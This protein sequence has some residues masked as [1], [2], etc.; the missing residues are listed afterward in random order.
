MCMPNQAV[1]VC[2]SEVSSAVCVFADNQGSAT[3]CQILDEVPPPVLSR[4]S[5]WFVVSEAAVFGLCVSKS[6]IALLCI[7]EVT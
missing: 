1:C 3:S 7:C 5:D 4:G 6:L 2:D